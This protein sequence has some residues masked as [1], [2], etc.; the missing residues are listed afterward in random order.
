MAFIITYALVSLSNNVPFP[1]TPI[2]AGSQVGLVT[3]AIRLCLFLHLAGT[4]DRRQ[5][6]NLPPEIL[7]LIQLFCP[8]LEQQLYLG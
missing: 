4:R 7:L 8:L 3:F 6:Q 2:S 5:S 1:L